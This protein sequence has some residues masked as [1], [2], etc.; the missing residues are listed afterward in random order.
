MTQHQ[1]TKLIRAMKERNQKQQEELR[2][3]ED[4]ARLPKLSEEELMQSIQDLE[5]MEDIVNGDIG[6]LKEDD[7]LNKKS[8]FDNFKGLNFTGDPIPKADP[9]L[10]TKAKNIETGMKIQKDLMEAKLK[11]AIGLLRQSKIAIDFMAKYYDYDG[12]LW[13]ILKTEIEAFL[14]S[15]EHGKD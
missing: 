13:E 1:Q 9:E 5:Q 4:Q 14:N 12:G 8:L 7:F 6:A 2:K 3:A 11:E 15:Q 10:E